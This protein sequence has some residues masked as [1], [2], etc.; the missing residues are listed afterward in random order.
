MRQQAPAPIRMSPR[1]PPLTCSGYEL[2]SKVLDHPAGGVEAL[3]DLAGGG[4]TDWLEFKAAMV[5]RPEDRKNPKENDADGYW[6]VAEA[7]LAMAN[8]R[9]GLELLGVD[10]RAKVDGLAAG[11]PRRVLETRGMDAFLRMEVLERI[12]PSNSDCRWNTERLVSAGRCRLLLDG[13]NECPDGLR[14]AA[15]GE[16]TELLGNYPRA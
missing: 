2:V 4:E 7:V 8:S 13:L 3:V 16:L 10:D 5:G 9:G 12:H 1:P 14:A 15:R 11:D 6:N